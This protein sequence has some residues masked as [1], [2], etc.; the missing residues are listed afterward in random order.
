MSLGVSS[1]SIPYAKPYFPHET[2]SLLLDVFNK[3]QI[4][5]SGESLDRFQ[6]K[7]QSL[8]G[9]Q[10]VLGVSNGSA[11]LRLAFQ[12]LNLR[13]STRVVLP[14][15]G[16]HVAANVA[17]SMGAEV[18][19]RDVSQDSWCL[20]LDTLQDLPEAGNKVIIVLI[21]SLGN[22]SSLKLANE[23]LNS[24]RIKIIEDSAEAFL[25]VNQGRQLGTIFDI[26]TYS[27]HA[28]KTITTGEGGF[29]SIN[30]PDLIVNTTLLRNHGMDPKNPYT[31][32]LPGDNFRISNL[33]ASVAIP[34]LES[35]NFIYTERLRVYR[36]YQ[37][38]LQ[39]LP[40][41][42]FLSETDPN[43]FFPWG[44]CVRFTGVNSA[45]VS[46]LRNALW[47]K[48]VDTRPGFTS[49]EKLPYYLQTLGSQSGS[50]ITSNLLALETL[51][52]PQYVELSNNQV[53]YICEIISNFF[54][55][56]S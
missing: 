19:F 35:I 30:A 48:G 29:I 12:A 36:R 50:L 9:S 14:G 8:L 4:S 40:G 41:V 5:G 17:Y 38:N 51:L 2:S 22:S 53:D 26:G 20:E 23:F 15:W 55:S 25:S 34:Q 52:L 46:N 54:N 21:H 16:F 31:H 13:P 42:K 32:I 39:Y 37:E 56:N 27:M 1:T 24:S 43:G 7:V 10:S 6:T 11:A 44:V 47:S 49:A 18:E 28:A 33:L 45:F 3:G